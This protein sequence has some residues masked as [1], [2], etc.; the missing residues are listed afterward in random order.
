M[1]KR[2]LAFILAAFL[3]LTGCSSGSSGG[4]LGFSSSGKKD[5][6]DVSL[7]DKPENTVS[8]TYTFIEND[9]SEKVRANSSALNDFK[10][11]LIS[12]NVEY[13]YSEMFN[14]EEA[15]GG[16]KNKYTVENHEFSVLDENGKFTLEH[17]KRS[18]QIKRRPFLA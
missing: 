13:P 6:F 3:L 16:I 4:G 17:F 9:A 7:F 8:N 15:I 1:N 2:L 5:D 11:E 18:K 12:Q 10:E 14:F